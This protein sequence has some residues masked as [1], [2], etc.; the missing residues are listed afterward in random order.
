GTAYA[1]ATTVGSLYRSKGRPDL[2]LLTT[3]V[4]ALLLTG[5][6]AAGLFGWGTTR[7]VATAVALHAVGSTL[8]F[9][10]A[11]NRLI[12]LGMRD[13]LAALTPPALASAAMAAVTLGARGLATGRLPSLSG[14]AAAALAGTLAYLAVLGACQALAKARR[15]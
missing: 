10:P 6:V 12:G 5:C 8:L 3:A 14:A 15:S 13:Y 4:R 2:E 7:A 11:A 1:L 9:Q